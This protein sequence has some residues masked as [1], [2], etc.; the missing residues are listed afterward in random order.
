MP[1]AKPA[2]CVAMILGLSVSAALADAT[3]R[4]PFV[5]TWDCEVALFTFTDTTY[6]NGSEDLPIRS[7]SEDGTNFELNFDDGYMISLGGV[8]E[9]SMSWVSGETFDQFEC[10]RIK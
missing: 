4:Y 5:G 3:P 8:T 2:L 1:F 7:V 9:T 6:N 10:T